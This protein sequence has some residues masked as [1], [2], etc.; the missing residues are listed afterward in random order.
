MTKKE[1]IEMLSDVPDNS[2][3]KLT[4]E[5]FGF[6]GSPNVSLYDIEGFYEIR[7]CY[8]LS[9]INVRPGKKKAND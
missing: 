4:Y 1:L 9:P 3:I 2:E 6:I 7:G 5:N 8:I